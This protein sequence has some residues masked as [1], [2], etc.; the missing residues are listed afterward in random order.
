MPLLFGG[1]A[2]VAVISNETSVSYSLGDDYWIYNF[3][4]S[5]LT[6]AWEYYVSTAPRLVVREACNR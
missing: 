6:N 5:C 1:I 4:T 2:T 3:A